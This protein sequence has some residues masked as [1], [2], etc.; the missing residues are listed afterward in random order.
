MLEE[1][2]DRLIRIETRMCVLMQHQNVPIDRRSLEQYK[3]PR[4][5][6]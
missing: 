2:L 1:I 5:E 4:H 3:E 6:E